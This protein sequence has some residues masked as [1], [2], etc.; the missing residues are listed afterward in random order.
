MNVIDL[1]TLL[2][3]QLY[4]FFQELVDQASDEL[5]DFYGSESWLS[6]DLH[7]LYLRTR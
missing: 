7:S 4:S 2:F 6:H 5:T 3:Y 1:S